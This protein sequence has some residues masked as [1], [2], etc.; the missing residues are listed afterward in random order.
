MPKDSR[1]KIVSDNRK[2]RH[3]Y[4]IEETLE[5]GIVLS[6]PEVKSIREGRVNLRDAYATVENGEVVVHN[7]HIS[8]YDK[9]GYE[10]PDPLRP[11]KLLLHKNEIR[12][13]A[14]KVREKGYTMVPLK[15]YFNQRGFAKLE[16]ALARGKRLYDKRDAMAEKEAARKIE[17]AIKDS[18]NRL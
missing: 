14:G 13:L 1:I 15:L 5:A 17:R 9:A 2:A 8:P 18:R 10:K 16:I 7:V 11:R 12:R 3:D 6:G 4:F